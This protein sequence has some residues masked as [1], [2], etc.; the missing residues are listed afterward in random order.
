M[1]E[2]AEGGGVGRGGGKGGGG[3]S[4]EEKEDED[5]FTLRRRFPPF[6]PACQ[7]R[8]IRSALCALA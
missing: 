3:R 5:K 1:K 6:R 2:K 4:E 7:H 8:K